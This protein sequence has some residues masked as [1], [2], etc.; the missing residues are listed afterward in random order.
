ML[1]RHDFGASFCT[2]ASKR[3][4]W[5]T[6]STSGSMIRPSKPCSLCST[7]YVA[8]F[9][10]EKL[11]VSGILA[12]VIAGIYYGWRAPR[13]LSG[14]MRLLAV[15]V[16]EMVVFNSQR[17]ALHSYWAPAATDSS[18]SSARFRL[19]YSQESITTITLSMIAGLTSFVFHFPLDMIIESYIQDRFHELGLSRAAFFNRIELHTDFRNSYRVRGD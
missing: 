1:V 18:R 15:P 5:I 7:P 6:S 13:I 4:L 19:G 17:R 14:R 3:G 8:Y 16:W 11:H 10:G 9:A 12:V 2:R